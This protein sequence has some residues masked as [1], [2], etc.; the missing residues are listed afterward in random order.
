MPEKVSCEFVYLFYSIFYF[1]F[2][3]FLAVLSWRGPGWRL[4]HG[5]YLNTSL[6]PVMFILVVA[7]SMRSGTIHMQ[8]HYVSVYLYAGCKVV[9]PAAFICNSTTVSR[10]HQP[11]TSYIFFPPLPPRTPNFSLVLTESH[12]H[13]T[14][15]KPFKNSLH[16]FQITSA[17]TFSLLLPIAQ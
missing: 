17:T 12:F 11:P 1:I 4:L 10:R 13:L 2:L 7:K 9:A 15:P 16:P 14:W 6:Y 8:A 5:G 3:F